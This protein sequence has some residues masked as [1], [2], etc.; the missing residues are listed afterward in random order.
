MDDH[1]AT[2]PFGNV[3]EY[4]VSEIS[5]AIRQTLESTFGRVRVRGEITEFKRYSSGHLY[6]SLK[7]ERGKL[8]GVVWRGSVSR[9]GLVPENGL[10]IIATGR[11]SA[12]GERSSYQLIVEKMEYAGEGALL[13]RIERLRQ[14]LAQ[15]GLFDAKRKRPI[16]RLPR[17]IGIVTS[18]QGAV[19]H[20]IRTTIARRFPRTLLIWP[21]AV[22]GEGAAAQIAGAIE[23]FA[24][25]GHPGPGAKLP[26][27]DV[28]IVARGGGS[29]EDLMAFN[30]EA[31]L[32]AVAACRIPVISAVG[33]ETDTTL[34]DFVSDVRAP[35]PTAAAE[36]AVPVRDELLADLTHR[37]A[38]MGS[39]LT[40][41]TQNARLRLDRAAAALPDLPSLLATARMRLDDRAH[42][43]E[44]ALPALVERRRAALMQAERHM[45]PPKSLIDTARARLAL[46]TAALD[47]AA[48]ASSKAAEARL[49]RVRLS[50][51][52]LEALCRE[53]RTR[54]SGLSSLLESVSPRAVL[55]RGYVLVRD[56]NGEPITRA[57][58]L[59]S[60]QDVAL[61]FAD[62][63]REARIEGRPTTTQGMLDL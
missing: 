59:K 28:L 31:V 25:V 7:D 60:G 45:P 6:F 37:V 50:P 34:I 23:G 36:M 8:S 29:L 47:A 48:L 39:A 24:E 15:E 14:K 57:A 30:D 43:L 17:V 54:I 42:R 63:T 27:P 51:A 11:V 61:V 1:P 41:I 38:R 26:R 40:R 22:Q 44:L 52:P 16:P 33:H 53:R 10:E 12:Y 3:P 9:L 62:A 21:V 32:R 20:D 55:E 18:L 58:G 56:H 4:S 49:G 19:L 35:T 5:G 46:R 13:A 2:S